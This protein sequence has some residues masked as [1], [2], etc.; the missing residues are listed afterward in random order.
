M[1][2]ASNKYALGRNTYVR[3]TVYNDI[4]AVIIPETSVC[5]SDGSLSLTADVITIPNNCNSGWKIKLPGNKEGSI[6]FTGHV[7][8]S[9]TD[10]L[11]AIGQ[12]AYVELESFDTDSG[13]PLVFG[14]DA[15]C[16]GMDVGWDSEGNV[17]CEASFELSGAPGSGSLFTLAVS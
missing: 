10:F 6:R 17:R 8:S 7:A 16:T 1:P 2:T 9:S 4:G 14:S 11:Q 13:T 5:I 12:N 15:V 3:M